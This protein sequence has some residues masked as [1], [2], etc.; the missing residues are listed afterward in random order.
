MHAMGVQKMRLN[1]YEDI[2]S[3]YPK[4]TISVQGKPRGIHLKK[5]FRLQM[6]CIVL[7]IM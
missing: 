1:M 6:T 2:E 4:G 3:Y 5:I 7:S